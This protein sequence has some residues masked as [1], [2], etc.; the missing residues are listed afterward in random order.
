MIDNL[1]DDEE[2]QRLLSDEKLKGLESKS[3]LT[4][5]K[6][7]KNSKKHSLEYSIA[8]AETVDPEKQQDQNEQIEPNQEPKSDFWR[9]AIRALLYYQVYYLI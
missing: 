2:Q 1:K 9:K 6:K 3:K 4:S 7:S 8:Y 5:K